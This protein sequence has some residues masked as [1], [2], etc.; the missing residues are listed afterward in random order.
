[1]NIQHRRS[2]LKISILIVVLPEKSNLDDI[3]DNDFKYQ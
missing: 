1:M 3:Q 2:T